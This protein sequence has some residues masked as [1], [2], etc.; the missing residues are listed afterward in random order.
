MDAGIPFD[1]KLHIVYLVNDLL[2]HCQRKSEHRIRDLRRRY[3]I[4]NVRFRVRSRVTQTNH[5]FTLPGIDLM[6]PALRDIAVPLF[7]TALNEAPQDKMCKL[8]K[9][10]NLWAANQY[11]DEAVIAQLNDPVTSM[12]NYQ[13][14]ILSENSDVSFG[15]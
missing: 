3:T 4:R 12:A 6:C 5:L 7:C 8:E 9:L 1:H 11:F 2:H 10:R 14:K 13:A 15:K